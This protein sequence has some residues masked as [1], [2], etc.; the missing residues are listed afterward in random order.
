MNRLRDRS[1][2]RAGAGKAGPRNL[3]TETTRIT[4]GKADLD[5]F[6][7]KTR[8]FVGR[9]T[10]EEYFECLFKGWD[11][12]N[13]LKRCQRQLDYSFTT[14]VPPP[15]RRLGHRG[16]NG[17]AK[18]H[19]KCWVQHVFT[20][21]STFLPKSFKIIPLFFT[22][23]DRRLDFEGPEV[24]MKSLTARVKCSVEWRYHLM[25]FNETHIYQNE[26]RSVS[27]CEHQQHLSCVFHSSFFSGMFF[28]SLRRSICEDWLLMCQKNP[29]SPP[30]SFMS[31]RTS[32]DSQRSRLMLSHSN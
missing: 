21:R 4:A 30:W 17:C 14:P 19:E 22:L 25:H 15:A 29:K 1:W 24:R 6:W 13:W 8:R 20:L 26:G 31:W 18:Q 10:G 2:Q 28:A 32:G 9:Q 27:G 16:R 11:R 7:S 23:N 5:T 3:N 12:V